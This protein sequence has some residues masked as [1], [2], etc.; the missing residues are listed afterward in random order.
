MPKNDP[1]TVPNEG[2]GL[3]RTG[4]DD[5]EVLCVRKVGAAC[6]CAVV[7]VAAHGCAWWCVVTC[8]GVWQEV[9]CSAPD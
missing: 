9:A 8:G 3:M 1:R 2:G 4:A 6:G 7:R 5:D